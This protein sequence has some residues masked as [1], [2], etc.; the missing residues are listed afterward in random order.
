MAAAQ[1]HPA[2]LDLA[3][4]ER[5]LHEVADVEAAAA[6]AAAADGTRAYQR[7]HLVNPACV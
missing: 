5:G 6:A 4:R 3:T 7:V 1:V 2:H